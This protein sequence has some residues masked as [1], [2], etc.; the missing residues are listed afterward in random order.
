MWMIE[1]TEEDI[2]TAVFE[3]LTM[4]AGVKDVSLMLW[5]QIEQPAGKIAIDLNARSTTVHQQ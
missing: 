3:R 5:A 2:T 1:V 4:I